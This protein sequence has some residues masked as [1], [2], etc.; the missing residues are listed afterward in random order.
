MSDN[1][2]PEWWPK[3][4]FDRGVDA[5][6]I[7]LVPRVE[8][9]AKVTQVWVDDVPGEANIILD[10][11]REGRLLGVEV[12]GASGCLPAEILDMAVSPEQCDPT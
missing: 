12:I 10:F 8:A 6:Y 9:G 2:A 3:I 4:T 5:A 7:Y 1:Q 11:D